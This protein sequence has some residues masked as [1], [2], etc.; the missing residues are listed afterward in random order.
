MAA[1]KVISVDTAIVVVLL[2][3]EGF[4]FCFFNMKRITYKQTKIALTTLLGGQHCFALPLT[5]KF[6]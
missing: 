6:H 4:L 3:L 1:A 2:E 5:G